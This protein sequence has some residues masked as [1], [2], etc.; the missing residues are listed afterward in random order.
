MHWI[1]VVWS[2]FAAASL[3][4][5]FIHLFAWLRKR[6]LGYHAA[7]AA[8]A[9]S[10]AICSLL[11]LDALRARTPAELAASLRWLQVPVATL[12]VSLVWFIHALLG[13]GRLW[14]GMVACALRVLVLPLH[15]AFGDNIYFLELS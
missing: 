1:E 7:F 13:T 10:M 14:L 12:V 4:L 3:T 11:E 2:M 6:D 9:A 8:I 15:F 5:G